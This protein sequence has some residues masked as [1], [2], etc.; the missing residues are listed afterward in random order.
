MNQ[1]EA[2]AYFEGWHLSPNAE[3]LYV[4]VRVNVGKMRA[5]IAAMTCPWVRTSDRVPTVDDVNG[6][7]AVYA[8]PV[9]FQGRPYNYVIKV[10][11]QEVAAN[12]MD[13]LL[14][15]AIPTLPELE[16]QGGHHA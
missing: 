11:W 8:Q 1:K 12:P 4:N 7:D 14:W 15:M 2:I 6:W 13:F 10:D 9:D 16:E 5:A 3:D